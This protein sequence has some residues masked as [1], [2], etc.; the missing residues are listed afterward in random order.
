MLHG[1]SMGVWCQYIQVRFV[2]FSKKFHHFWVFDSDSFIHF[3]LCW[4]VYG[5]SRWSVLIL[6]LVKDANPWHYICSRP[7][8]SL[9]KILL[10]MP[11]VSGLS[12]RS[13]NGC[14][15][16]LLQNKRHSLVQGPHQ[17][18]HWVKAPALTPWLEH[19]LV[20]V[21]QLLQAVMEYPLERNIERVAGWIT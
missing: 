8:V 18:S 17:R 9:L 12:C 10:N 16:N 13:R 14:K 21:W 11:F 5:R 19:P 6:Q 3:F 2:C 15:S 7:T 20:V 4:N 1:L